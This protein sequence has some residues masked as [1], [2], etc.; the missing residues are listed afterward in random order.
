M[1]EL[2]ELIVEEKGAVCTLTFNRPEKRNLLT[3][4]MLL[5]LSTQLERLK[6]GNKVRCVVIRGSGEKAFS[7]GYDISALGKNDMI[8][9]HEGKHPVSLAIKSIENF[10]YPI[11]AMINGHAF[12]AGLEIAVTSDIRISTNDCLFGM[13]PVKL[14]VVYTYTG[15]RRFINLIGPG[16]TKELFLIGDPINAERAERIGLVN[17]AMPKSKLEEF[18]YNIAS[19]ISENAPLSLKAIKEIT[20]VWQRNQNMSPEDEEL[21]RKLTTEVQDSEDY[22]EGQRAFSEKR[23][24][25][26][27]GK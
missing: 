27:K 6:E 22:K 17:F 1:T 3:P 13:P 20:N 11:I 24:P 10:P 8:E 2:K 5:E 15:V 25:E 18:T 7:S 19:D 26:F 12:G 9:N 14:G 16:Y 4:G 23:K 21:I